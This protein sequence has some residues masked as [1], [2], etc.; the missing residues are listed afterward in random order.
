ML[1]I[2]PLVLGPAATNAY[3]IADDNTNEAV[4]IDPAWDGETILAEAHQL[5]WHIGQMWVTHAHFDHFAGAGAI[6]S[7]CNPPPSIALHPADLPLWRIKGGAE[8]F[9]FRMDTP[10]QPDN[11][12]Q[13]AQIL[14]V[15][16]YE[17]EVRTTPGHSPGHV[18][19]YCANE[20][21]LFCGDTIF[22]GS[23]GRTDLP[24]G[25]EETLLES[26]HRQILT[27]PDPTR[28]LCGHGEETSVGEEKRNNL[29]L[30]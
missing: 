18:V 10:P 30:R 3:L 5:D 25:N 21:L 7:G 4:V 23:I 14:R 6:Q 19:F 26:I 17:F 11:L 2:I 22:A 8:W 15:G 29:Y 13:A 12:L 16:Q 24:G 27:L 9:G 20:G 28:L 1:Q